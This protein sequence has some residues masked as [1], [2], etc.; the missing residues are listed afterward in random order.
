MT[1]AL[2]YFNFDDDNETEIDQE[3]LE[4]SLPQ[5]D[6]VRSTEPYPLFC[7]GFGSGKSLTM[8]VCI[9]I[10]LDFGPNVK[11]GAYAPTF[12]LL[13]LIT[14]PYLKDLLY[15]S[16]IPYTYNKQE[17]IFR[18]SHNRQIICRSMDNPDSIVG[19]ETLRAHVD[20]LDT[21]KE[22]RANAAW[23]KIIA[24]NRQ[25]IY[26]TDDDGNYITNP[27]YDPD[28]EDSDPLLVVKNRV[29][30]YTTPE[31]FSFAYKR[32]IKE[33]GKGYKRYKVSTYS[34][35]KNLPPDYIDNLKSSYPPQLIEAYLDGE[36]VN[37]TSGAVYPNFDRLANHSDE[38]V[39][40]GDT[41]HIG[42]DFN[43]RHMAAGIHVIRDGK[44]IAVDEITDGLD[45][46]SV[47][48]IIKSRY[49]NHSIIVYPDASGNGSSSKSASLSD[50]SILKDNGFKVKAPNANPRIKDR[51]ASLSG[52]ICN[53]NGERF[54]KVNTVMC[55]GITDSLER[56]VYTK[57]GEPDKASGH[58]HHSDEVGYFVHF[59]WPIKKKRFSS[60]TV[61][62]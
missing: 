5:S 54:Y 20:E 43:V 7:G 48:E 34:N 17:K 16:D 49:P 27:D 46:P 35:K 50:I 57:N 12:D 62:M 47:C 31:G 44:P 25:K 15:K 3:T 58:D 11:I 56:Q 30:G 40:Q 39:K 10:D 42:M 1:V 41:L 51:V 24:R 61:Y 45:T 53:A 14:V 28:D 33:P 18:L 22:E 21:M 26:A 19:Y 52:A 13:S 36:F 8:S 9:G 38:V 6:F 55:P 37:L 23:N 60:K 32:W 2:D 4:L 59:N 29:S